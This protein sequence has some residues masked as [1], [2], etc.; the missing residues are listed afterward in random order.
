MDLEDVT[1]YNG[2]LKEL[3]IAIEN[4]R[5]EKSFTIKDCCHVME[6]KTSWELVWNPIKNQVFW[7]FETILLSPYASKNEK[8]QI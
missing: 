3:N 7:H 8:Y 4:W 6:L 5:D 1:I 2:E